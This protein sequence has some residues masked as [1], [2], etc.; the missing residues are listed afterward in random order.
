M[1][2]KKDT[3]I[4][5]ESAKNNLKNVYLMCLPPKTKELREEKL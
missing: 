3:K 2:K 5:P 4:I 1:M